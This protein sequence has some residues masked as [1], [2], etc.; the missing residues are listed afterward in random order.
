[1]HRRRRFVWIA[2][3]IVVGGG[4]AAGNIVYRRQLA[5][6]E[7]GRAVLRL[8]AIARDL[9]MIHAKVM[10]SPQPGE[11]ER[12]AEYFGILKWQGSNGPTDVASLANQLHLASQRYA[13]RIS[14]I[15]APSCPDDFRKAMDDYT[16]TVR[17]YFLRKESAWEDI[18]PA[19]D[20]L[21]EVARAYGHHL[22]LPVGHT[23]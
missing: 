14:R 5:R 20:R 23:K 22:T 19:G 4:L 2:V 3:I 17:G 10:A 9:D 18:R 15:T 6:A 1:M 7:V 16:N 8:S 11:A 13:E 21:V 12:A